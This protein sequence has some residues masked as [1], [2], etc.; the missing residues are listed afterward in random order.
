[1]PN[2]TKKR[3][4][5]PYISKLALNRGK[6]A[7]LSGPRQSGKTTLA[8]TMMYSYAQSS[9]QNWDESS[10]RRIWT[11]SPNDIQH[12][13]SLTEKRA[14]R[15]L[16]LDEIHK[17]KSWKQKLKGIYDHLGDAI[18]IIV[19]GS[20]RLNIYNKGGDSLMGRYVHFRL[21]P[22]SLGELLGLEIGGH[23]VFMKRVFSN[24]THELNCQKYL[25]QLMKYGGFPEPLFE[26]DESILNIWRQG[27]LE[28]VVKQDLRDLTRIQELGHVE[29][30]M[31]LLPERI[32]A[33]LST[34]SL[35]EDLEVSFDTVKRWLK[36]LEE[37]Y[38]SFTIR[39][40]S[41]SI[42]RSLKKEPK[43]YLYDWTEIEN[44]A[45][46]FENLVA[47]HL[48]KACHFWQ[49]TGEGTFELSYLRDKQKNEVDFLIIK[50]KKPWFTVECKLNDTNLDVQ[51]QKF[52]DQ[53]KIP[54]VQLVLKSGQWRR[55]DE[56]SWI[57][58]AEYFLPWL[59]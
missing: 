32:G 38:Y 10:F 9:Y 40:Y 58:S 46:R 14:S 53:L 39:P 18:A 50:N 23:E 11:K 25:S 21:H 20:A 5:E 36:Y 57:M 17:S 31:A 49:D 12:F 44:E 3:Y 24:K 30:L 1:M 19:T 26:K 6:M 27:R 22:F 2:I 42:I 45:F 13:F 29:A 48:L 15:L 41:K 59:V 47:S 43:L 54:H 16:I 51:Y 4:L 55:I 56:M 33:P 7:F 37:L 28:K 34:A 35:R 8:K 52:Q